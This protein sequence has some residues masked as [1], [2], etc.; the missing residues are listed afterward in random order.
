MNCV[1]RCRSRISLRRAL[2]LAVVQIA[3]ALIVATSSEPA[4]ACKPVT[5]DWHGQVKAT[6]TGIGVTPCFVYRP[7]A[8]F[9]ALRRLENRKLAVA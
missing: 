9:G 1:N 2:L 7:A 8:D 6:N 4:R 5:G 3:L